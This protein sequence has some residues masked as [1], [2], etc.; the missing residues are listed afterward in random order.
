MDENYSFKMTID[1]GE[2]FG[3]LGSDRYDRD[4][5]LI[6]ELKKQKEDELT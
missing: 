1:K 5:K 3:K 6:E 4:L 2:N